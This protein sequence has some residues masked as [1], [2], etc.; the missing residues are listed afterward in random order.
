MPDDVG[1]EHGSG[2]VIDDA[3]TEPGVGDV[4]GDA[5]TEIHDRQCRNGA[6]V[7]K[8]LSFIQQP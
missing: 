1:T 8:S 5:G 2:D 6:C 3:G 4:T 7:G